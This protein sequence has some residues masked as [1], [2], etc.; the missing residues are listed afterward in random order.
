MTTGLAPVFDGVRKEVTMGRY[1]LTRRIP[2]PA[3]QVYRAFTEPAMVA[4]WMD[5]KEVR[6]V[7]GP[8]D[9]VGSSLLLV[10]EGPWKFRTRIERAERP[11]VHVMSGKAPLGGAFRNTAVLTPI[12]SGTDLSLTTEYTVPLGPIGRLLD[13]LFIDKEPRTIANRELDRLV[14]IV[15]NPQ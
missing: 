8:L 5:M 14:A 10:V 4:D 1:T 15:S 9:A 2:A 7:T 12:D 6:D 3:E 11:R 13:R